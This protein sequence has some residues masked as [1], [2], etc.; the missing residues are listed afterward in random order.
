MHCDQSGHLVP[1][2]HTEPPPPLMHVQQSLRMS[3]SNL[4]IKKKRISSLLTLLRINCIRR[5]REPALYL[6][7]ASVVSSKLL[8][9]TLYSPLVLLA[10]EG[11]V[12]LGSSDC[13]LDLSFVTMNKLPFWEI[14]PLLVALI[15]GTINAYVNCTVMLPI[16]FPCGYLC[17]PEF[18]VTKLEE[19][20]PVVLNYSWLYQYNPTINWTMDTM[21][22][23][24]T[25][26]IPWPLPVPLVWDT[27]TPDTTE[28]L[29]PLVEKTSSPVKLPLPKAPAIP[30]TTRIEGQRRNKPFIFLVSATIF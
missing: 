26:S 25:T 18:F 4:N 5:T 19:N 1:D 20:Y 9:V 6:G 8:H 30:E 27:V 17:T 14:V 29:S 24:K 15:D 21:T 2:N 11:L 3:L 22:C 12:D 10:F 16:E 7:A 13:F 28:P 23:Q